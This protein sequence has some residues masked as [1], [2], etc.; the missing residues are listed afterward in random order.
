MTHRSLMLALAGFQGVAGTVFWSNSVAQEGSTTIEEVIVTA[1]RREESILKTPIAV[2]ALSGDFI[3]ERGLSVA[4]DLSEFTPSLQIFSEQVN[5]ELYMIRGIGRAN[6]DLSTD[7]G[8]AVYI[9]G[10]YVS[11]QGAA[12][13]ALFDLERVEV[14][15]GPQG[16]LYGKNAI[17]GVINLISRTPGDSF[18]GYATAEVGELNLRS[19]QVAAGG[20]LGFDSVSGRVAAMSRQKDGAYHSL[21]TG[22]RGNDLDVQAVRG[23]L[24]LE[25]NG[26]F[27]VT[28]IVDYSDSEQEGVLKSV[29]VDESGAQYIFKDFLVVN[30]FPTQEESI[31]TSLSDTF[32]SQGVEQMGASL[33]FDYDFA[34][35]T[36]TS[37]SGYRTEESFNI[38]DVDRTAQRS[39]E[40]GGSQDTDSFSQEF[41]FV[42]RDDGALSFGGRLRW[43]AGLYWFHEE[44]TRDHRL[45]LNARVPGTDPGD[46]DD[47]DNGLIG[48]GSPDAQD[49]TAIFLQDIT[50]DSYAIFGQA[51][52]DV[53]D[54]FS[55]TLGVRQTIEEKDFSVD[56]RSE[57]GTPGGDPYTLFQ[58]EGPFQAAASEDWESFT[59]KLVL[60]YALP[61][62]ANVYLSYALG[63]KSGG[64]NGQPDTAASLVPFDPEEARNLELGYKAQLFDGRL[65][66][67]AALFETN[68][69]DLQ[70][71]G[72][73]AA[74]LIVT[75]NAADSRIRGLELELNARP[76]PALVLRAA[77]SLLDAGFRDYFKEEFDPTITNGPPFVIVDKEGDRLD[78][79]PEYA[80]S[81]GGDYTWSLAAGS[82]ITFGA[83]L[84]AKGDTVTNENTQH[85]SAYEVVNARLDWTSS[86]GRWSVGG[87]VRNLTDETY[88]RGGGP[89]PDLNKFITRVGLVSDPRTVGVTLS[90]R[91]GD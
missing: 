18:D 79:T 63:F 87:W 59:P 35:S 44:G 61:N 69:K 53:T 83:D 78:D 54:R 65:Q 5:T 47:P 70:V 75:G 64:F 36:F 20:P 8:V 30:E 77:V 86:D 68:V 14:L 9:D 33:R 85:A 6:E 28:G 72:T 26:Q 80:V 62:E 12:N 13:A 19:I 7:S 3:E 88:Y 10:V 37:L 17:G 4:E 21:V 84:I 27:S 40:Q 22:D 90:A 89:V 49:S 15:R 76:V 41:R 51:T 50:T 66:L 25:P 60:A 91:F 81:L 82:G 31:R 45:Y 67:A 46:P 38:E 55:V 58:S 74:G 32:G 73:N 43:T 48:P 39:L 57:A 2:T 29:I 16:T 42:S 52:Y 23:S 56:A 24:R 1:E 71:A 34:A 11:Q